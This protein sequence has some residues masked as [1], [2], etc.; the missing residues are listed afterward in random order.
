MVDNSNLRED[1]DKPGANLEEVY[2]VNY[3]RTKYNLTT[4]EV[5]EAIREV[6][7]NNPIDVEEYL[8]EK[9]GIPRQ[10]VP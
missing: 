10:D 2:D 3:L 4:E 6:K 8:S 7:S 5:V 9:T 1:Q